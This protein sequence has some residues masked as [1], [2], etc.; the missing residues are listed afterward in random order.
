MDIVSYWGL[1]KQF[2]AA[3]YYLLEEKPLTISEAQRT[4]LGTLYLYVMFGDYEE[5]MNVPFLEKCSLGEKRKRIKEWKK[6]CCYSKKTAI[7][8]FLDLVD[9]L[10]PN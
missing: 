9:S 10:F 1:K 8:K 3:N 6:L 4:Q 7:N 5:S 2:F